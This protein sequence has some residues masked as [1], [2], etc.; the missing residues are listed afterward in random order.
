MTD[1]QHIP[2]EQVEAK[3]IGVLKSGMEIDPSC[4]DIH[5][6]MANCLI[7]KDQNDQAKERLLFIKNAIVEEKE[8]YE[9][10]LVLQTAKY[11]MELGENQH[12]IDVLEKL[13]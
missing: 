4:M 8:E 3:C 12:S 2:Y 13:N 10:E 5:L 6:Q 7:E 11:L 1:L 9:D